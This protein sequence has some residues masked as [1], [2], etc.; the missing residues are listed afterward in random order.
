MIC[1]K[2]SFNGNVEII[3]WHDACKCLITVSS[4]KLNSINDGHNI[5]FQAFACQV[6]SFVLKIKRIGYISHPPGAPIV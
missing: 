5:G 4:T 1:K 6:R 3:K 2:V